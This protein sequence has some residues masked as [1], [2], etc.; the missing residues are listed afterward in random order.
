LS[1][2]KVAIFQYPY[3]SKEKLKISIYEKAKICLEEKVDLLVLPELSL[4]PYFCRQESLD[5][6]K[7]ADEFD[8][9][10]EFFTLLALEF[11]II[12]IASLFE[13]KKDGV[14]YNTAFVFDKKDGIVGFHRK[15]HIPHDN[16]FYE[17]YYFTPSDDEIKPINTSIG[18]IGLL[19]C[20]EQWFP[21]MARIMALKGSDILIYPTAIG[22]MKDDNKKDKRLYLKAWKTIQKSHAIANQ[23][24]LIS[25]N[26]IGSEGVF[27]DDGIIFWG[28]SFYCDGL[29]DIKSI[30]K[31]NEQMIYQKINLDK[32]KKLKQLWP[33]FR[34]RRIDIYKDLLI[35]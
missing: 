19:I 27:D 35:R 20:W 29:G 11:N 25:V 10:L 9:D 14:Y 6:F 15:S 8:E 31:Q 2:I 16:S 3:T 24:P 33:F 21:E 30:A 13:K 28:N 18:K 5:N 34:D 22:Y 1:D 23:I 26:R 17:K 12:I 7:Y 32:S 4:Y